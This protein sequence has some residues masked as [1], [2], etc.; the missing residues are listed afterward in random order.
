MAIR[1]VFFFLGRIIA[2]A[3]FSAEFTYTQ[4]GSDLHE[5]DAKVCK[6]SLRQNS[7]GMAIIP[8]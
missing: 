3:I 1:T 4:E 2:E 6:P 7:S 5:K 8:G